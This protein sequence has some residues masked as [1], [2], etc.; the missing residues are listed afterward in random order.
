MLRPIADHPWTSLQDGV[1]AVSLLAIVGLLSIEYDLFWFAGELT[2]A[3]RRVTVG[4]AVALTLMLGGCIGVFVYRRSLEQAADARHREQVQ[5]EIRELREQAFRDS[6]TELPNRRAVFARL[7]ELEQSNGD[8][9]HAFFLLD[10]NHFKQVNDAHGHTAGDAVL[11]VVAQR[12]KTVARPSDLLGRLGGD[13][14][15]VLAYD[16]DADGAEAVGNRFLGTLQNKVFVDGFGHDVGVSIGVVMIPVNGSSAP[17]ILANADTAMY[18]AKAM[19]RSALVF[20][21]RKLD[22]ERRY[23]RFA[24]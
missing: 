1:L 17:R 8:C 14:F 3:E 18:R 5:G 15:A 12:F 22:G 13:E 11:H 23:P 9:T 10:L 2:V 21:D 6:L 7:E 16:V 20:Y 4:E 24:G 19:G